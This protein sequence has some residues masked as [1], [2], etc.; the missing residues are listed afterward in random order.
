MSKSKLQELTT[1]CG[2]Y[3]VEKQ[4]Q[5]AE[6]TVKAPER[7]EE[8]ATLR[9]VAA[10]DSEVV[11]VSFDGAMINIRKEGWKEVKIATFSA[12]EAEV[13]LEGDEEK[14]VRLTQHSYRAGL[15]E[16]KEFAK[17]QW[18]EGCRRGVEK[19]RQIACVADGA[20]WIW[21]IVAMC[22]APCIEIID[23]W[24]AVEK[25]WLAGNALFGQGKPEAAA[26]VEKQKDL[27]WAGKARAVLHAIRQA[28]PR[29]QPINAAVWATIIYIFHNRRRMDYKRFRHTGYP[30]GSGSV[31]SACKVVVQQRMKQAGMRWSRRGAQAMLAL[32]GALLSHQWDEVW[33]SFPLVLQLA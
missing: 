22:Y 6:A 25:L 15:W 19:A 29:G 7:D 30:I 4:A 5:E 31:E 23:W 18:A 26:W 13:A 28:C 27:L 32:R 16:A 11:A 3:L 20:L 1:A 17:Q 14:E 10:P 12:V 9:Q 24:H 8:V 2:S 21:M 33:D